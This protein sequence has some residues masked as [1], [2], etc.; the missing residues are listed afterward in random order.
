MYIQLAE[1]LGG[2][3]EM[4][5]LNDLLGVPG[6]Q[7]DIED[8]GYPIAVDEEQKCE[9]TV[10][11]CFRDN[12]GVEAIAKVNGVDVVAIEELSARIPVVERGLLMKSYRVVG[13]QQ[14]QHR[15]KWV[16]SH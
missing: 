8:K 12:I 7:W 11:S 15:A 13:V 10:N 16:A 5:I 3:K 2:V 4:G 14:L 9:K 6:E 1:N